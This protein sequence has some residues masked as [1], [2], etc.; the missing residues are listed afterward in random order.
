MLDLFGKKAAEA[1][2]KIEAL[3][4]RI[5]KME[6]QIRKLSKTEAPAAEKK[7]APEKAETT[8]KPKKSKKKNNKK[9]SKKSEN[10]IKTIEDTVAR[11]GWTEEEAEAHIKLARQKV[12]ISYS[13][14]RKYKF[15]IYPEDKMEEGM[16]KIEYKKNK[17]QDNRSRKQ[18]KAIQSV[19]AATGWDHDYTEKQILEA[20]ART[21]CTHT[22]YNIYR[23]YEKDQKAQDEVFVGQFSRKIT[24]KYDVD[25]KFNDM[26][27][28]KAVTNRY[29]KDYLAR[30]WCVNTEVTLEEFKKVFEK[31]NKIFYK[32]LGL[33]G[34]RGAAPFDITP[35]N[36]EAVYNEIKTYPEGVV[37]QYV[38]QHP[39]MSELSPTA[40]NTVRI[41]TISSQ[42]EPIKTN[43]KMMDIPYISLKMGGAKS[44]VD[45]LH[46]GGMVAAVDVKTGKLI[47]DA[48][49]GN[50]QPYATHP[51]TGT[52]I[53]GFEIPY[54]KEAVEM[55]TRAITEKKISG[56][57]G[58]DIAI[59]EEGP[60]LIEVNVIPGVILLTMPYLP[61]GKGMKPYMERY[62]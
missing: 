18:E 32:P 36:I 37:E 56:Y 47:T 55:V 34:G 5:E 35:D 31:T 14:Y 7:A 6:K 2:K 51:A 27:Y 20:Q 4:K 52:T 19:M 38:V 23:F 48:V 21:G 24:A 42:K 44:I 11:S 59:T 43:G 12:G 49:D 28:D 26:L 22:E 41:V 3:E 62:L 13:D 33:N 58:W 30:P 40:V 8:E 29:F 10:L 39:K 53:K 57:L 17:R 9:A 15:F 25:K 61:E 46:G 50:G 60:T 54:F 45:N 16:Q 1:N